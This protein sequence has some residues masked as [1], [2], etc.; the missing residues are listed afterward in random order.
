MSWL[1]AMCIVRP[2]TYNEVNEE[3]ADI[4][5]RGTGAQIFTINNKWRCSLP[6]QQ[7]MGIRR[8]HFVYCVNP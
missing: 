1:G 4:L 6:G 5:G 3:R 7:L 2:N 8:Q